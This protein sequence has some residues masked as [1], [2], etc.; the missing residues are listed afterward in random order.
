[1]HYTDFRGTRVSRLMLGTVQLGLPYGIANT[2]GQPDYAAARD[3]IACAWA[4]G[5]NAFDT[6]AAYG[7]SEVVLGRAFAELGISEQVVVATKVRHLTDDFASEQEADAAITASVDAS[8]RRLRMD[9]LPFVLFHREEDFRYIDVLHRL[10]ECGWIRHVGSSVMTPAATAT[11]V[12]SGQADAV[13]LPTHLLDPR[14][15]DAGIFDAARARGVALFARSVY[16]QGL[17]LMLAERVPAHLTAV[18]PVRDAL[19]RLAA[20]AG[21]GLDE[22]AVR[23]VLGLDG[24]TALLLGV[25]TA[26]QMAANLALVER[27][28]LEPALMTAARAVV[29]GLPE[30]ILMPNLW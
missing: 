9:C 25:E 26:A 14:Y 24:L 12:E 7:E 8:R 22:L 11:I 15:L 18:L 6:A 23:Y 4:G 19:A 3:I 17:L 29:P 20:D 27:G 21:M 30:R 2:S 16:F 13:Q 1:M 10:R 28:P 5:V